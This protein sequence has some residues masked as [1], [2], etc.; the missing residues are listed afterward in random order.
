MRFA[1]LQNIKKLLV[2]QCF[3]AT[4]KV[5]KTPYKTCRLRR[6][7]EPFMQNRPGKYQKALGFS[8]KVDD[9]W[10]LRKMSKKHWS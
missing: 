2:K 10:G 9:N 3:E 7:L 5:D 1:M 8:V 4:G 6:L